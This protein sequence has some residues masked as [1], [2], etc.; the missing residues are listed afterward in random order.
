[1]E[2][3]DIKSTNHVT[4]YAAKIAD[5]V[6]DSGLM[7]CQRAPCFWIHSLDPTHWLT[8]QEPSGQQLWLNGIDQEPT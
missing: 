4:K 5:D 6:V 1:M 7:R 3:D 8:M 2:E